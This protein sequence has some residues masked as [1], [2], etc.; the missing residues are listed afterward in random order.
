MPWQ[1]LSPYLALV[2][3]TK[4]SAILVYFCLHLVPLATPYCSLENSNSI[5]NW[6]PQPRK[7][8]RTFKNVSISCTELKYM[9]Y[10]GIFLSKFGLAYLNYA[11]PENPTIHRKK[12]LDFLHRTKISEILADFCLNLVAM[13]T[14]F[15]PW[16]KIPIVYL[17]SPTL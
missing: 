14:P 11:D 8:Y 9:Q 17:N 13:A 3:R 15:A 4:I 10:F 6:I 16:L 1:K 5:F 2:H 7:S 12:F